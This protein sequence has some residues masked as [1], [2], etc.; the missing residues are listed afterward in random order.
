MDAQPVIASLV[1]ENKFLTDVKTARHE[2]QIDEPEKV[3][4]SD[5]A[6]DPVDVALGAL[7]ACTAMTLKMYYAHKKLDWTQIDV[8]VRSELRKIDK[9]T[10]SEELKAMANNGKVRYVNKTIYITSDMDEKMIERAGL[11]AEKCPVN[12]M[13]KNGCVMETNVIK[14]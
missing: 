14:N 11:I 3:G 4:G 5:A 1:N 2:F 12:L 13:M 10:A 7:G 9:E 8:H 6:A